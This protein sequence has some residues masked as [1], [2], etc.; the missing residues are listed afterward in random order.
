MAAARTNVVC[1]I[2]VST[3]AVYCVWLPPK[4]LA[5]VPVTITRGTCCTSSYLAATQTSH[6][7]T[8]QLGQI[9]GTRSHML[10]IL[11]P[12]QGLTPSWHRQFSFW[13]I[14][15]CTCIIL[16][17]FDWHKN[18]TYISYSVKYSQ[19][20]FVICSIINLDQSLYCFTQM[21]YPITWTILHVTWIYILQ[22]H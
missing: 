14:H 13:E 16:N 12:T 10:D 1:S 9:I 5:V 19:R 22:L 3:C 21:V 17:D 2:V 6:C 7:L 11:N 15:R 4:G 20:F 8:S 18:D